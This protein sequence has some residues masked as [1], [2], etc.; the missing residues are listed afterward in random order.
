MGVTGNWG[1]NVLSNDNGSMHNGRTTE[2][3]TPPL[4]E[5]ATV[6]GKRVAAFTS[7]PSN[8]SW[9]AIAID[10][11]NAQTELKVQIG[12]S[13]GYETTGYSNKCTV[14]WSG[15][16]TNKTSTT[17]S[18]GILWQGTTEDMTGILTLRRFGGNTWLSRYTMTSIGSHFGFGMGKKTLS[19]SLDRI[20]V[21]SS[22]NV[23]AGRIIG[24][25]YQ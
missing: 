16:S 9:I 15:G 22:V 14:K 1:D 20:K 13:G 6:S 19:G 8:I 21:T 23:G 11:M 2:M 24:I 18:F 5:P 7:I 25:Q 17:D 3:Q 12:D 4:I 10:R